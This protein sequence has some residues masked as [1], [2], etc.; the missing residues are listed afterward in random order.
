MKQRLSRRI[1]NS[2]KKV[3]EA[4]QEEWDKITVEGIEEVRDRTSDAPKR[5]TTLILT[6][7]SRKSTY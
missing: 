6:K 2:K 5:C 1:F 7:V 3:K 4:L